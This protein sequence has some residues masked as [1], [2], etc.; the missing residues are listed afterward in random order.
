[1]LEQ[2]GN[3]NQSEWNDDQGCLVGG[4]TVGGRTATFVRLLQ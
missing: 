4:M 3:H 2:P 1:M